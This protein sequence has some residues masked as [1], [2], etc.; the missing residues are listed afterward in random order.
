MFFMGTY[1]PKLDEKGRLFLPAKFRDALAEG[2]VIT[3]GQENCLTVWPEAT[4]MDEARRAQAAGVYDPEVVRGRGAWWE[5]GR[6][7]VHLGNKVIHKLLVWVIWQRRYGRCLFNP[8]KQFFDL[9]CHNV[10]SQ[11]TDLDFENVRGVR[12]RKS[13]M[14]R[15]QQFYG[16]P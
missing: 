1:T 15:F 10:I 2:L 12:E 7:A 16:L 6:W 8:F 4:F 3:Q 11:R 14:P 9:G 5:E 13:D